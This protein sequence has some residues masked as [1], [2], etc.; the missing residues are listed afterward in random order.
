MGTI[1]VNVSDETEHLFRETVQEKLGKEKGVL[2]KAL[3]EAMK[4]WAEEKRQHEIAQRQLSLL[5]KGFALGFGKRK[6][7]REELYDQCC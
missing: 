3:D 6:I 2:G 5:K 7:T 4:Q 1:T